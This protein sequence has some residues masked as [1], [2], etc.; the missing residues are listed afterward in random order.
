MSFNLTKRFRMSY[1]IRKFVGQDF[2][3]NASQ[4]CVLSVTRR[5]VYN[6]P[7]NDT[8][9]CIGRKDGYH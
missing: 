1:N 3:R 6:E 8:R 2:Y 7:T 5:K 9:L 4:R